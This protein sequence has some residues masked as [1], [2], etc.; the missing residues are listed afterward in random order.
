MMMPRTIGKTSTR[1]LQNDSSQVAQVRVNDRVEYRASEDVRVVVSAP[2]DIPIQDSVRWV[3]FFHFVR[4][5]PPIRPQ[6]RT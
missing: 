6:R 5:G 2:L 3:L 1:M 4:V